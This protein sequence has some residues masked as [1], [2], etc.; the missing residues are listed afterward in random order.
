MKKD[1]ELQF[2]DIVTTYRHLEELQKNIYISTTDLVKDFEF[3]SYIMRA[4]DHLSLNIAEH[5]YVAIIGPSGAGKTTFLHLIAG[6][7]R[8]TSGGISLGYVKINPMEEETL[9]TYRIFMVG[10]IFQNYNLISSLTA[11]ENIMFPMQLSG[12]EFDKCE[13]RAQFLLEQI[14]L[15]ERAEHLPSQLSAGEQQRVAI[16]RALANDPPIIVADE[17]TANLDKKNAE[18]IGKLFE[19]LRS[20][21][22]T[23]IMATHDEKLLKHAHR[24]LEM[25]EGKIISD[26][27]IKKIDYIEPETPENSENS[28]GINEISNKEISK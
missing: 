18:F 4:L 28:E 23:I 2:E 22:K 17:P 24:I 21:G 26:K 14:G 10:V 9:C 6:L 25:E 20:K 7:D 13:K 8:P 16:A 3:D 27:R 1:R 19:D 5:E 15:K 11:L 12:T